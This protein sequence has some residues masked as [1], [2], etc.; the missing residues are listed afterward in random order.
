[1]ASFRTVA[2]GAA[3]IAATAGAATAQTTQGA[4]IRPDSAKSGDWRRGPEGP[5]RG[6]MGPGDRAEAERG[7]RGGHGMGPGGRMGPRGRMGPGARGRGFG[8]GRPG[9]PGMDFM[10]ELNL[11][12]TQ[13]TQVRAIHEKYQPQLKAIRDRARSEFEATRDARQRGDTAAVR[14]TLERSRQNIRSQE[15]TLHEQMFREVRAVLTADQRAKID[16]KIADRI[17]RLDEEKAE[18]QRLRQ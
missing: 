10:R 5:R 16:G 12:E 2:L 18:L 14:A 11:T 13:R 15:T 3:L 4:P 8:P 9:M 6:Q 7:A 17:K 1:M